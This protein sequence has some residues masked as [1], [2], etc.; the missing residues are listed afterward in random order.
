MAAAVAAAAV[1]V[2]NARLFMVTSLTLRNL[3]QDNQEFRTAPTT[4][5]RAGAVVQMP[6]L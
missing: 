1:V 6:E 4:R 5:I 3:E 2:K